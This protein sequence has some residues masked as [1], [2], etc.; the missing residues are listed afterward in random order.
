M[1]LFAW[2]YGDKGLVDGES[3][4]IWHI[5]VRT[6]L[7]A[8]Y[9]YR[10]YDTT[11]LMTNLHRFP[12]HIITAVQSSTDPNINTCHAA[13]IDFSENARDS[14]AQLFMAYIINGF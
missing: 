11:Y 8:V 7:L 13:S 2:N 9:I 4:P 5:I 1:S 14:T 3:I 12:S 10:F 6:N